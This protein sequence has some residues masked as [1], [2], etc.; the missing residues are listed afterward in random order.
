[1][2]QI[3]KSQNVFG[4]TRITIKYKYL[5]FLKSCN[6]FSI[7][8][9]QLLKNHYIRKMYITVGAAYCDHS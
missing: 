7:C 4:K 1:M 8:W 6:M 5:N 3:T 2:Y 9:C